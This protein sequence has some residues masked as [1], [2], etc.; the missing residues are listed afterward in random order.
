MTQYHE[1]QEVEVWRIRNCFGDSEWR[2]ARIVCYLPPAPEIYEGGYEVQFRDGTR[3]VFAAE[4]IRL[5]PQ[6]VEQANDWISG[7]IEAEARSR[8]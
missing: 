1:G 4:H 6:R 8:P 2:K 5:D 7:L 3:G